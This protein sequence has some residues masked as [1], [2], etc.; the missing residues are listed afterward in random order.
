[1]AN[2]L[3][4]EGS[5]IDNGFSKLDKYKNVLSDLRNVRNPGA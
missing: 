4:D 1:M 5:K 3:L 2:V